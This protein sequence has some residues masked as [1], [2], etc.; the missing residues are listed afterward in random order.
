MPPLANIGSYPPRLLSQR[1]YTIKTLLK[2]QKNF[3][4]GAKQVSMGA[5]THSVC[6]PGLPLMILEVP[7]CVRESGA[8][9]PESHS[10]GCVLRHHAESGMPARPPPFEQSN[11]SRT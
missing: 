8:S 4:P 11:Q 3:S 9:R 10:D 7:A 6:G 1:N 5:L 2:A